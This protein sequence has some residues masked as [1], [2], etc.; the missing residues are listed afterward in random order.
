VL[1]LLSKSDAKRVADFLEAEGYTEAKLRHNL[2]LKE[3]ASSR[4]RNLPRL[5]DA[6][7]E[8]SC[9]NTLVRWFWI[10]LQQS[11]DAAANAVPSWFIALA[12]GCGLLRKDDNELQPEAMLFPMGKFLYVADHTSKIDNGQ[13]DLVLWPNPTSRLLARCTI[14]NRSRATLDLGTGSG[15]QAILASEHSDRVVGTDLNARAIQFAQFSARLNEVENVEFLV[16]SGFEPLAGQ[17]FDLIVSNPPFFITPIEQ[18]LFCDN[19]L[20]LDQLCRKFAC[21]APLHLNEGGYYQMLCEWAEIDRQPWQERLV[22][23]FDGL[24][25]DVWVLKGYTTDPGDYAEEHIRSTGSPSEAR[26]AEVYSAYME[27]YRKHKVTGIH[28]GLVAMHRRSGKNW[29]LLE[30]VERTPKDAF[31]DLIADTFSRR[32]FLLEREHDD[33]LLP[34]RPKLSPDTRLE[35]VFMPNGEAW[36]PQG[37]TLRAAKE[38]NSSI[39]VQPAVAEFL[40]LCDGSRSLQEIVTQFAAGVNAPQEQVQREC[41]AAVR[42][43]IERGFLSY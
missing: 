3:L 7:R 9:L 19:P 33:E 5:K 36:K 12:L 28:G 37:L 23:W 35:Q 25:C 38:L 24:G 16:G 21:E 34:L 22:E 40:A 31:G 30:E 15:I 1:K 42:T 26:D 6:T 39:G 17:K 11:M 27:Y 4:L 29:T 43:L 32:T 41:L 8:P 2:G 20:E 10:G 13:S 18:Y 14:R